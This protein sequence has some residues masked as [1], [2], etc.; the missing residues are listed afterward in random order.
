[1][2]IGTVTLSK[3]AILPVATRVSRDQS[4]FVGGGGEVRARN[5]AAEDRF[6]TYIIKNVPRVEVAD[7][8][9]FLTGI[10]GANFKGNVISVTDD[11]GTTRSVRWWDSRLD[12]TERVGRLFDL[13]LT[14]RI[15]N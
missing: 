5:R 14:F 10:S 6:I 2:I 1:M 12:Y 4:V 7:L 13:K 3:K 11:W 8:D 9:S 15:E